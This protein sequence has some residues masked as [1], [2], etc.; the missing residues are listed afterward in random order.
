[1]RLSAA[2]LSEEQARRIEDRAREASE[3]AN[4]RAQDRIR[5]AQERMEQKLE[6][7]QR[8]IENKAQAHER[9]AR[10]GRHSWSFTIPT[11]PNPVIPP[12]EPVSDDE[13]LMILRMLE[14]KK[15][16][17][18]EAEELLSALEGKSE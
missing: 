7:A 15:I 8:K 1:M 17:M 6:R 9:A 12:G 10:H 4:A 11:P 18:E 14:Q 16:S 2:K 13:R 5:H 3:R